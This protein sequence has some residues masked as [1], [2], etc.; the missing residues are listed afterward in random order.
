[1]VKRQAIIS[2]ISSSDDPSAAPD[3]NSS[4]PENVEAPADDSQHAIHL[5]NLTL[6]YYTFLLWSNFRFAYTRR[7]RALLR[8]GIF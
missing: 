6:F 4:Q 7:G 5:G 2:P 3:N 8:D 1:M